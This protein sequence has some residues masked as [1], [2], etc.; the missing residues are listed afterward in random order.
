MPDDASPST[1]PLCVDLD[2]TLVATDALWESILL[3]TRAQPTTLFRL[4]GWLMSGRAHLKRQLAERVVPDV[5][6][7]PYRPEVVTAIEQARTASRPVLLVTA[8]DQKIADAVSDHLKLFDEA[9]GSDGTTNLKGGAKHKFLQARFG[10]GG[11]DYIGDSDADVPV[12]AGARRAMVVSSSRGVMEKASQVAN[13]QEVPTEA[14]S[15]PMAMLRA[16]RP[17]Q[18]TKNLLLFVPAVLAHKIGLL[19]V[20]SHVAIA[21]VAFGLCASAVYVINDLLDLES[22]RLHPSKRRRPFAAGHLSIPTGVAM[23]SVCALGGVGLA[24]VLLP[25]PFVAALLGYLAITTAYSVYLKR[26]MLVDI[27]VLAL[28]YTYRVIAGGL[29][30]DVPVSFWL[31]AFS[32]FF[33]TSLAFAKRYSELT[34][35]RNANGE[36]APGRGY[37]VVD[38]EIVRSVGP[39]TGL[40]AVLVFALYIHSPKVRTLYE[41]PMLMWAICPLLMY[42]IV[43]VW[44]LAGRERLDDD[45]IVFAVRDPVSYVVGV[46]TAVCLVLATL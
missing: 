28:L 15:T 30:V 23:A 21:F 35:L 24:A 8:S 32:M 26:Q 3:A 43:R 45:P 37:S 22:D 18:W 14:V 16:I 20:T 33:F 4:L 34:R 12:W 44:F 29:A 5:T 11:Y 6:T 27:L 39:A 41:R 25:T 1:T 13:A 38:L 10:E 31:L 17:H 2:G 9:A 42:W 46:L 40:I 7:W 19:E 36:D